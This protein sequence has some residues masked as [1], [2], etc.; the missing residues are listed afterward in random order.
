MSYQRHQRLSFLGTRDYHSDL[1][2]QR[3]K[4]LS[5]ACLI[6]ALAPSGRSP[7]ESSNSSETFPDG[8]LRTGD[9]TNLL[10]LDGCNERHPPSL[11]L[12]KRAVSAAVLR[13]VQPIKVLQAAEKQSP[14]TDDASNI[15]LMA[16]IDSG[17]INRNASS[18][19]PL[20]LEVPC[21][22]PTLY[23]DVSLTLLG[24]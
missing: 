15:M 5:N 2:K 13:R 20:Y 24:D 1:V 3:E 17:V 12:C 4:L 23:S 10:A 19:T 7:P 16:A 8:S 22:S 14:Y 18:L 9:V 21:L 6:V 11:A